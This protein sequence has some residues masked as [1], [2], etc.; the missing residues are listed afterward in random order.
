MREKALTIET[1]VF[2]VI[3]ALSRVQFENGDTVANGSPIDVCKPTLQ[4]HVIILGAPTDKVFLQQINF[5]SPTAINQLFPLIYLIK[6]SRQTGFFGRSEDEGLI[7]AR[8]H[9]VG[10]SLEVP[11]P[12]TNVF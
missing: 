5:F 4:G 8:N 6:T 3:D 9:R 1:Q 11:R 12:F 7:V 2:E 10:H